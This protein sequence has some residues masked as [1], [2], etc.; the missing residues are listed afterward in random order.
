MTTLAKNATVGLMEMFRPYV[1]ML[2][3]A[4]GDQLRP[5]AVRFNGTAAFVNTGAARIV[6]T[7]AHVYKR[8]KELQQQEPSLK[9][10]LTGSVQNQVLELGEEYLIADGGQ[11]V[12]LAVFSFPRSDQ[13]EAIGK[14]Y[15]RAQTW[16]PSRPPTGITAVILG[17]QGAHRQVD[18]STLRINLTVICDRISSCSERHLSLVDED[19]VR[20]VVKVNESL[21]E[22]GLLGGMSGSPVFTMDEQN[23]ATLVGFLYETGQGADAMVFA[24]H[25]DFITPGGK[26]DQSRG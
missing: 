25:A 21:N 5:D 15:F 22:L 16:P 20:I 24:V 4:P 14:E 18:E 9:M 19:V 26:I 17:F 23:N 7:N 12:D 6:V 1:G 2:F 11:T 3:F 13:I 8:F 10:F